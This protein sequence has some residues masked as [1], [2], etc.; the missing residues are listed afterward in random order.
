MFAGSAAPF[1]S[2]F[3]SA[4]IVHRTRRSYSVFGR[5]RPYWYCRWYCRL[6]I[7]VIS[8]ESVEYTSFEFIVR[9]PGFLFEFGHARLK[10]TARLP[11]MPEWYPCLFVNE[12]LEKPKWYPKRVF[13]VPEFIPEYGQI[14]KWAPECVFET[15]AEEMRVTMS[16]RE[17]KYLG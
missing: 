8:R 2:L 7:T 4:A 10:P 17:P 14:P 9:M 5:K 13:F 15:S 6:S 12:A 11:V 1:C 3:S 16:A